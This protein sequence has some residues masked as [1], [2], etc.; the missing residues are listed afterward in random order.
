MKKL[1]AIFLAIILLISM[2]SCKKPD[3]PSGGGPAGDITPTPDGS[4]DNGNSDVSASLST[5]NGVN[6]SSYVIVYD[7]D[8]PDYNKRAAEYIAKKVKERTGV[9][10]T[11]TTDASAAQENEIVV[12]E[13]SRDIS[14]KLEADTEPLE[15]A[16]LADGGDVAL[17]A[18]YF[19]IAAAAYFFIETYVPKNDYNAEV[20]TEISVHAPIVREAKNFIMLIG[21]GMGENHTLLFDHLEDTTDYSDGESMFYGYML[22]AKGYSKTNS[23][24]GVTDSAAGGTALSCGYKTENGYLGRLPD[25]TDLTSLTELAAS[26]GMGTAVLSTESQTGA[27]PAS[28]SS[29]ANN[30]SDSDDIRGDQ[31]ALTQEFGTQIVC[32]FDYYTDRYMN[33]SI[34]KRVTDTLDAIDDYD[35]GLFLMYEEAHIDKHSHNNDIEKTFMAVIR[36]NQVI[37]RYME[38]AFYHPD[39]FV[40]ITAD[41]ETGGL[42]ADADGEAFTYHS[43]DHTGVDV[44]I[45]AYGMGSE[46]FDGKTMENT[47]IPKIIASLMGVSDF[48]DQG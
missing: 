47:E 3:V 11:V 45:F 19:V 16:I 1:L 12:G 29:H 13:T 20:P 39:T 32:G 8:G 26:L 4:G 38:F 22:P 30:R 40:L 41:H 44:P 2:I 31:L 18:D 36:F 28:F 5:V 34:E 43:E 46:L 7:A 6:L 21:D 48:G 17:E 14:E 24:T 10:L 37:A 27:T 33:N 25:G 23:L 9:D 15:F 35:A 42:Y